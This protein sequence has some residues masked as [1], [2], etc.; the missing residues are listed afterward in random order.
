MEK[1]LVLE[2]KDGFVVRTFNLPSS[3][4]VA[5]FR[6][7]KRRLEVWENESYGHDEQIE[8]DILGKVSEA[9]LAENPLELNQFGQLRLV[10]FIEKTEADPGYKKTS[11]RLWWSLFAGFIVFM[12]GSVL[13]IK[14][15]APEINLAK[16]EEL[17]AQVVQIIKKVQIQQ[18]AQSVSMKN[19]MSTHK[20]VEPTKPQ[21]IARN[22]KRLGAL[23]VL[24]SLTNTKQRGG[25]NLGAVNTT[26]GAGLG[27]SGGSG[28]VQT[29]LYAKGIIA[30]PVGAGGNLQGAG[31]YGTKGKGG[32]QAG[33]GTLSLVG[34]AGTS[35]IPLGQEAMI[36]GGLD[37]DLIAQ[38]VQRN[39]G[40]IRFCYEQ[41]LQLEPSL[42]GRVVASWT[43]NGQGAVVDPGISNSAL[44]SK[45]VE[46]CILLRLRSWKFPLPQG[47]VN[48]KVSYPFQLKRTGT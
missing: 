1:K 28:G 14:W 34:S 38:V 15:L 41:G 3:D 29:S 9:D 43:I 12:L 5:V 40:Q 25:L 2:N 23:G 19:V 46:D 31:G 35:S 8:F 26:A 20:P 22:V 11:S 27:G 45:T 30:A 39:M 13:A 16:Q 7:D 37:R 32:G 17:Q 4:G 24:G 10:D 36:E 48:V 44:N 6:H 21:N 18:K 47:G 33:Y 42:A